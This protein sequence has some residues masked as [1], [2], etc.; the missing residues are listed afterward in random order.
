ML[1]LN[2]NKNKKETEGFVMENY[3]IGVLVVVFLVALFIE[4]NVINFDV[5]RVEDLDKKWH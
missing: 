2:K 3:S 4:L 5:L 1:L